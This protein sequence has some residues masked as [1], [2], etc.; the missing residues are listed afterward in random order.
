MQRQKH[1]HY[2][3]TAKL[4]TL[5][6]LAAVALSQSAWSAPPIEVRFAMS[7]V[8]NAAHGE[9]IRQGRYEQA[10][11][12]LGDTAEESIAVKIN[13]CVARVMGGQHFRARLDCHRAVKMAEAEALA[14]TEGERD[15]QNRNWATAL[16]NRGVRRALRRQYGAEQ[17][18]QQALE[19]DADSSVA[20]RNLAQLNGADD[21][22]S[23]AVAASGE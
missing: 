14:A 20:V 8:G 15:A 21:D 13:L 4:T 3:H 9:L 16:S 11:R 2:R 6:A 12:L 5:L 19:L 1:I 18:F 22:Y 7:F 17:D 10:A 23:L